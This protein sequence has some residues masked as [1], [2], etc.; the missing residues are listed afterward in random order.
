[1]SLLKS[2]LFWMGNTTTWSFIS[3]PRT[4]AYIVM[5]KNIEFVVSNNPEFPRLV[6][7][8][9]LCYSYM[10][11]WNE[12]HWFLASRKSVICTKP[13]IVDCHSRLNGSDIFVHNA[14]ISTVIIISCLINI[15]LHKKVNAKQLFS[16]EEIKETLLQRCLNW[17]VKQRVQM[18]RAWP[19]GLP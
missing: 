9:Q 15:W 10:H 6:M 7:F 3:I 16:I 5:V 17:G 14:S 19:A 12:M 13:V 1:M 8:P 11:T 4:F 18:P 2:L